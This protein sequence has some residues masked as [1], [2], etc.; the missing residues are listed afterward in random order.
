ML[1]EEEQRQKMELEAYDKMLEEQLEEKSINDKAKRKK[2]DKVF[3][4]IAVIAIILAF[5]PVIL[6]YLNVY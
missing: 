5:L 6:K 3:R 4:I 1:N 2:A